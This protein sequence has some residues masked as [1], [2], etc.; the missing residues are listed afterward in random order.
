M[1]IPLISWHIYRSENENK[2]LFGKPPLLGPPWSCANNQQLT[3]YDPSG[4][5]SWEGCLYVGRVSP[6][7]SKVLIE[8][9]GK[10]R[11]KGNPVKGNPLLKGKSPIKGIP[12]KGTPL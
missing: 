10:S 4:Q 6:L 12:C 1:H 11:I 2:R 3:Y 5:I 9:K 7:E 8:Y